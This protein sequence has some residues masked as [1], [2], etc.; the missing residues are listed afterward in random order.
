[1]TAAHCVI[2]DRTG[3]YIDP[4]TFSVVNPAARSV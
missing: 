3:D 1:M 2:D 4:A